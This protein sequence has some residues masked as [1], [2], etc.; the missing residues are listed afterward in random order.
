MIFAIPLA[1]GRLTS[2]FG[3]CRQF[4]ILEV[5]NDEIVN[6][7]RLIPPP[8][9]PGL[10][11]KWLDEK[12][13]NVIIAGGMG[14]KAIELFNR[15]GIH[16]VTGAPVEEPEILVKNYLNDELVASGNL[17]DSDHGTGK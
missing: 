5:E 14:Q 4:A 10:L 9:E 16:V 13:T 3:Q 17:C 7:E 12:G 6:E 11:P 8:H 15:T 1:D 2:H